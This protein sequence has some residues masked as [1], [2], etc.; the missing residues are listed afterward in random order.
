MPEKN[1][2]EQRSGSDDAVAEP[3]RCATCGSAVDQ[4]DWHPVATR[5]DD[6][7]EFHLF[8]FCSVECRDRW[9]ERE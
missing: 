9:T 5:F 4:S 1:G 8:A 3:T 7:G 6:D 2:S